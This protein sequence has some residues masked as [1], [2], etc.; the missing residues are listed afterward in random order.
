M[1]FQPG[2]HSG[3]DTPAAPWQRIWDPSLPTLRRGTPASPSHQ[4]WNASLIL[5]SGMECLPQ[6]RF[7]HGTRASPSP[8]TRNA[9]LR[10][11]SSTGRQS[12]PGSGYGT[13]AHL[14]AGELVGGELDL[15]PAPA[16]CLCLSSLLKTVHGA[17][18]ASPARHQC[19]EDRL[20]FRESSAMPEGIHWPS[21]HLRAHQG[22]RY[23]N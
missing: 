1:E 9:S 2:P 17:N 20:A 15:V 8:W 11:A 3:Y 16:I 10:L 21:D 6:P 12:H 19:Q 23:F 22:R 4:T 13:A 14:D 18:N 5:A 7:G